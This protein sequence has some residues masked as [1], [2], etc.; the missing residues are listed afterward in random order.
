MCG[1]GDAITTGTDANTSTTPDREYIAEI[2]ARPLRPYH[3]FVSS[4]FR[5]F[6]SLFQC[7]RVD[8]CDGNATVC[9]D[10]LLHIDIRI[11]SINTF[12]EAPQRTVFD[13]KTSVQSPKLPAN[14]PGDVHNTSLCGD[15]G[16]AYDVN[17]IDVFPS[18][19][20][21]ICFNRRTTA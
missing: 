4:C 10:F 5:C 19:T 2:A 18:A 6:A 1:V 12:S 14:R 16:R 20:V 15:N 9:Q 3:A 21:V 13:G 7:S 8:S 17:G 11:V